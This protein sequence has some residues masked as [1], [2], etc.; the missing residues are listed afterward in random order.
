MVESLKLLAL[1]EDDLEVL[2]AHMQDAI[3]RVVDM[4]WEPGSNRFVALMNRFDWPKAHKLAEDDLQGNR[5]KKPYD[6]CRCALRFDHVENVQLKNIT[7]GKKHNATL[8]L[9]AIRFEP[10]D[11]P[12]GKIELI[13]AGDCSIRL[14]VD[15]IEAE[16]TDLGPG[17]KVCSQP[18]HE[19]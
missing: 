6:R 5:T 12:S 10:G 11:L 18:E 17:W 7:V 8:E 9:L 1:D 19:G 3:L 15:C 13:F 16:L 4:A 14:Q 2:S